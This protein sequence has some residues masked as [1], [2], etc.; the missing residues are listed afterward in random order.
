MD[1]TPLTYRTLSLVRA[2]Q[3]FNLINQIACEKDVI[4]SDSDRMSERKTKCRDFFSFY[5]IYNVPVGI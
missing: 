2:S 5:V 4:D 1:V 3:A